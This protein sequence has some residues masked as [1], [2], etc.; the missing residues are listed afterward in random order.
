MIAFIYS[1]SHWVS[2]SLSA[3]QAPPKMLN[4]GLLWLQSSWNKMAASANSWSLC[5]DNCSTWLAAA[6][7]H[8][9]YILRR[10][11]QR[12]LVT[13]A[14]HSLFHH[15]CLPHRVP[16]NIIVKWQSFLLFLTL[17]SLQLSFFCWWWWWPAFPSIR[18]CFGHISLTLTAIADSSFELSFPWCFP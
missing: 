12:H 10:K 6:D 2:S 3:Q 5:S 11:F 14:A 18:D 1:S 4:C 16:S 8:K 17:G 7:S 13:F 15:Y 9:E